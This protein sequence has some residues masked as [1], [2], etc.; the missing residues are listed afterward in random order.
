MPK[1]VIWGKL[2]KEKHDGDNIFTPAVQWSKDHYVTI[3]LVPIGNPDKPD[4]GLFSDDMTRDQINNLI[5]VLRRA[6]DQA[7]GRDE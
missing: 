4:A 6:R 1:E 2:P 3:G 5:K 7:F